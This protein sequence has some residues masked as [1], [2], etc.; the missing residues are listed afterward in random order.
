M[1]I[2][3][4]F[5]NTGAI[6]IGGCVTYRLI[7]SNTCWQASSQMNKTPFF[8]NLVKGWHRSESFEINLWI[9]A[10]HPC[11]PLSSL[12]FLRGC[13]SWT[14]RTPSG[15]RWITLDVTTNR[16]NLPLATPPGKMRQH[17]IEH[18]LQ[19][20]YVI[21][22]GTIFYCNIVFVAFH[23]FAYMLV[24]NCIH[25]SLIYRPHI[26]QSEGHHSIAIH[27]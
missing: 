5:P 19:I 20:C 21:T 14:T 4:G 11:N 8:I 16:R 12:R 3:K 10:S 18:C 2:K 7:F 23:Y 1:Y 26:L 27:S 24:K 22:L 15:S 25:R 9:Q 13:I 6:R 17:G